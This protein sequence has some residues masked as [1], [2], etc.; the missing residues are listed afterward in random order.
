MNSEKRILI[1][2]P[3]FNEEAAVGQLITEIKAG[4][5]HL[6]I[7]VI[8]DASTD[9]TAQ[10]AENAGALVISNPYNLG[11]GGTIQTGIKIAV[12]EGYDIAVQ[13]DGDG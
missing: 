8:D 13:M 2:V 10:T 7:L 5:P 12:D 4:Y 1:V 9:K 3:A 6:D 11:I